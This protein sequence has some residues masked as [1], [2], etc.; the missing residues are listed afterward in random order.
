MMHDQVSLSLLWSVLISTFK[1]Q[2]P[3]N[4]LLV[5]E[6][7]S[8]SN[9]NFIFG[10]STQRHI[11]NVLVTFCWYT[12]GFHQLYTPSNMNKNSEHS[13][14]SIVYFTIYQLMQEKYPNSAIRLYRGVQSLSSQN[15]GLCHWGGCSLPS[16]TL[17][18]PFSTVNPKYFYIFYCVIL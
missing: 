17:V 6:Y 10:I 18:C 7:F 2:L 14:T 15:M 3:V 13:L 16:L 5:H 8:E 12:F 11:E 9:L 4:A 1:A